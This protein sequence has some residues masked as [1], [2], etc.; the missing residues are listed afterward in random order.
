[1]RPGRPLL[2]GGL[3]LLSACAPTL[4]PQQERV[5]TNFEACKSETGVTNAHLDR[6]EADGRFHVSM[7]QTQTGFN[8]IMACM[9]ER[10]AREPRR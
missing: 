4:T 10:A 2:A 5:M 6:V 7:A 9:Q 1:V 3:L 8:Q